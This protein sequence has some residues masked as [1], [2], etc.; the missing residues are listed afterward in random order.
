MDGLYLSKYNYVNGNKLF[1]KQIEFSKIGE[2]ITVSDGQKKSI[3]KNLGEIYP[4]DYFPQGS[5][6][7]DEQTH[8]LRL[9][10]FNDASGIF[11]NKLDLNAVFFDA[12]GEITEVDKTVYQNHVITFEDYRLV[13]KT[14][15]AFSQKKGSTKNTPLDFINSFS[16]K[17]D[18][19]FWFWTIMPR[20]DQNY[21]I[22]LSV[23]E[24]NSEIKAYKL[25]KN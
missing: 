15:T 10:I 21:D 11:K 1:S 16:G 17:T 25:S 19:D 8:S 4:L 18:S 12:N 22:L 20:K 6:F 14:V 13:P 7:F 5:Y 24:S 3:R 23:K 2:K 9:F